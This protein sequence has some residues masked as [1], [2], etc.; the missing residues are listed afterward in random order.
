MTATKLAAWAVA[1][2]AVAIP[3]SAG[4]AIVQ[5]DLSYDLGSPVPADQPAANSLDLY[6]PEG[7]QPKDRRPLAVYVHG[8]GW[9]RGDKANRIAD[10]AALFTGAGYGFAS[11]NYRLSPQDVFAL[12]P[13]RIMFPDHPADVGE[14]IGWLDRNAAR[15][16]LD[17][18]RILLVGHSAG[19]HL[20]SLV[21]TDPGYV[22]AHGVEPWQ[23]IGAVA[24]DTE[25]FDVPAR[26]ASERPQARAVLHNAFGTPAQSN[27][28]EDAS[29]VTLLVDRSTVVS[30]IESLIVAV[31]VA[32]L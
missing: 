13:E 8:G 5:P 23:V 6:L 3:T 10:K 19:A 7:T 27:V 31:A 12:D 24:L 20:V 28:T 1:V 14:A 26:I 4:A 9:I 17:R 30:S 32:P 2:A 29:S 11:V 21:G 25:T 18:R 16:G 22:R 15:Y